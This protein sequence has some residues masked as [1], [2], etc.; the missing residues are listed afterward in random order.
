MIMLT[1]S[2]RHLMYLSYLSS[3][4]L[5][6]QRLATTQPSYLSIGLSI[7]AIYHRYFLSVSFFLWICDVKPIFWSQCLMFESADVSLVF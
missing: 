1:Q 3:L 6:R 2:C 7:I 4:S 5:S